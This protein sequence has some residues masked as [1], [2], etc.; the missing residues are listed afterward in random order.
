MLSEFQEKGF[1]LFAAYYADDCFSEI[2]LSSQF[3]WKFQL[4]IFFSLKE[5]N[6]NLCYCL[7]LDLDCVYLDLTSHQNSHWAEL[8][9]SSSSFSI[10]MTS[11]RGHNVND[12]I[13]PALCRRISISLNYIIG[14]WILK[15]WHEFW[16]QLTD[17]LISKATD[18]GSLGYWAP[19]QN[20]FMLF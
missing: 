18:K 9:F 4:T 11:S 2:T 8:T 15:S 12:L 16:S 10:G 19:Q 3:Y 6:H 20:Y 17:N 13:F 14:N 5:K 1:Y 7:L